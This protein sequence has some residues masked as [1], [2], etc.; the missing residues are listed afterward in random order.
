MLKKNEELSELAER[1]YDQ[2]KRSRELELSHTPQLHE[3]EEE[4]HR[5]QDML[6]R[7][8]VEISK[9]NQSLELVEGN[10]SEIEF[11]LERHRNINQEYEAQIRTNMARL[12]AY[13]EE[14]TAMEAER[15]PL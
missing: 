4:L 2:E 12:H 15:Q 7:K 11:E 14:M 5:L 9:L 1:L 13:E 3:L 6:A 10:F 8:D